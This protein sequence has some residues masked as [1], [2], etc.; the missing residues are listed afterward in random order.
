MPNLA[1]INK[2]RHDLVQTAQAAGVDL[3]EV[4]G[5]GLE[6][7]FEQHTVHAVYETVAVIDPG[8]RVRG[9]EGIP[10]DYQP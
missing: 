9:P 1:G 10:P 2:H 8:V 4:D 6:E 5:L 3:A 7:L